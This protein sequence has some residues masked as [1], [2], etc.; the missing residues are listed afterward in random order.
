MIQSHQRLLLVYNADSGI[1]NAL[2]HAVHK[3]VSPETYP[4]SLCAITYGAVSMHVEW[5]RFLD[6]LQM[7]VVIHHKDDFEE[8]YPG[9]N[10]PLPAILI[11]ESG[12]APRELVPAQ[13]LD[14]TADTMEL[15]ESVEEGLI[16]QNLWAPAALVN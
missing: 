10:I 14:M 12:A 9:H 8:T 11:A 6:S 1:I 2:M 13:Q 7:E 5:R 3:Q 16:A 15:M 4:C